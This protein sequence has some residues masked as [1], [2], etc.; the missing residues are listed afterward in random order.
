[1]LSEIVGLQ[2]F[3]SGLDFDGVLG[4]WDSLFSFWFLGDW[5][6]F[7][8]GLLGSAMVLVVVVSWVLLEKA[9]CLG[10][11]WVVS[12]LFWS[13]LV[14]GWGGSGFLLVW[15]RWSW[16]DYSNLDCLKKVWGLRFGSLLLVLVSL[17][18]FLDLV[19][20]VF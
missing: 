1:M 10:V 2:V 6:W 19:V 15:A 4:F 11:L 16:F 7:A 17:E 14:S 5:F 20:L 12:G 3:K 9:W 8:S 18:W 13:L